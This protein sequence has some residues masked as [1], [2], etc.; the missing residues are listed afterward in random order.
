M[1]F[2]NSKQIKYFPSIL[3]LFD[4]WLWQAMYF[5]RKDQCR[6]TGC[7]KSHKHVDCLRL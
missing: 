4:A 2:A 5:L 6:K 7:Q 1:K 3:T